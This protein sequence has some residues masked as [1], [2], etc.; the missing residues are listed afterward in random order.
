MEKGKLFRWAQPSSQ[1]PRRRNRAEPGSAS[2]DS[3]SL[4]PRQSKG[5]SARTGRPG[6]IPF[7]QRG[8]KCLALAPP[9]AL[10]LSESFVWR[11]WLTLPPFLSH[12]LAG[13]SVLSVPLPRNAGPA[14]VSASRLPPFRPHGKAAGCRRA[15]SRQQV[16]TCPVG[17]CHDAR[18]SR[19]LLLQRPA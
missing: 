2:P 15:L 17:I 4:S 11:R 14:D 13:A 9:R 16:K 5:P 1:S 7:Q 19:A 10:E 12:L 18:L 8:A 3:S 6:T